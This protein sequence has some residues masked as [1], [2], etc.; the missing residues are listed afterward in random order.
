MDKLRDTI[1]NS[2]S[3]PESDNWDRKDKLIQ[4]FLMFIYAYVMN[5]KK[6]DKGDNEYSSSV[7]LPKIVPFRTI[8]TQA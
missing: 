5:D 4:A 7:S 1:F 2:M 8:A 3:F 6:E